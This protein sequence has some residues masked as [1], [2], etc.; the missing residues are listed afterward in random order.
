MSRS[1]SLQR[2]W[3]AMAML[4]ISPLLFAAAAHAGMSESGTGAARVIWDSYYYGDVP[5]GRSPGE[6]R[7]FAAIDSD[8]AGAQSGKELWLKAKLPYLGGSANQ[9]LVYSYVVKP[10]QITLLMDGQPLFSSNSSLPPGF[11]SWKMVAYEAGASDKVLLARIS[12]H[13]N[14]DKGFE[15]WAGS[16]SELSL[17]LLRTE[18][19]IWAGA[20]VL[21]L[22]CAISFI[23]YLLNRSQMLFVYFA[24]FFASIA[25][26]LA[27]LWGSWQYALPPAS[28]MTW[29]S[30]IHLNWYIGHASGILVTHTIVAAKGSKWIRNT[31]YA[32]MLYGIAA[33]AGW[34]AFGERAQLL[35]YQL[36]YDYLSPGLLLILIVVL[37]RALRRRRDAEIRIFAV[38]NVLFVGGLAL[39]RALSGQL[40]LFPSKQTLLTSH[41]A[42]AQIGWTFIG[43]GGA[44][45][46]LGILIMMRLL[47]MTRLRS[48]NAA[49]QKVNGELQNANEKLSRIDDIRS[50][51]Y[52]EVSHEL[53][54][55]ITAI[56][57]YVQ[58]MLNGTIPPGEPRYLQVIHDKTVVMERMVDDMLEIARLENKHI[59]F[60]F[61]LLP[62]SDFFERLCAKVQLDMLEQGFV[63]QWTSLPDRAERAGRIA[64]IYAD[65]MRVE[66]VVIN[67]LSNARKFTPPGGVIRMEAT[68]DDAEPM[69]EKLVIRISDS[70]GGIGKEEREHIFE[71]YYRGRSAK[72]GE[73]AGTGLGLTI[74]RE[75]MSAHDGEIGLESSS[76]R[77]ST[78]YIWFPLRLTDGREREETEETG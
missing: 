64:A 59:K 58:L 65:R 71:R 7:P 70:G 35:F 66:Q 40:G 50:N 28:L 8:R 1:G 46:C 36:F 44:L 22:L 72:T 5:D 39:G 3:M 9:L 11:I 29:G 74:C 41:Q 32:V 73:A 78:F 77:G 27:V 31:G 6:W 2:V 10:Y 75:I 55:P 17:K 76:E 49:L 54:T 21:A 57:G 24:V 23:F 26:D 67:V 47:H 37:I 68:I 19:P 42:F 53:N 51:M 69:R 16:S 13:R 14:L 4:I 48:T 62:F 43:F 30:L 18:A 15:V 25:I 63:F 34:L 33:I 52:S 38:G 60:D 56:K 61:E 12:P 20:I 45:C